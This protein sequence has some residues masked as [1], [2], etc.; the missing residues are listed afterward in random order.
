MPSRA[1]SLLLL[2]IVALAVGLP[3]MIRPLL[4]RFAGSRLEAL[5]AR[6]GL[7]ASWGALRVELPAR[8]TLRDLRV[9]AAGGDTVLHADS[10]GLALDPWALLFGRARVTRIA[11]AHASLRV[12]PTR[13]ADIDTLSPDQPSPPGGPGPERVRRS[14][15]ALVRLLSAPARHL[16]QLALYDVAL[17]SARGADALWNGARLSWLSLSPARGGVRL[18]ATGSI[19]GQR[20]VPFEASFVHAGDDRL[21]GGA[22]LKIPDE[23]GGRSTVRVVADAVV[24][25]ER[26]AD[27]IAIADGSRIQIGT[28]ELRVGGTIRRR[29]PAVEFRLSADRLTDER[30]KGS[31]PSPV[32][33]P[34]R[35]LATRGSWDYR[36][37]FQLDLSRPDSVE[38]SARVV[39][40]GLRLDPERTRLDLLGLDGPFVAS[41]HLPRGHL[42]TR[43][44]SPANPHFRPLEEIVPALVYAVVTNEDGAFFHH[45]GF[46]T[47]AVKGAIV[48]NL[49]AGAFRR[50]AGTITMQLARNLYLGHERTLSRKFQEVTLAWVLEHLTGI[51]KQ[52]LLE[53]YLNIIE[54][55]PGIHGA[56]EAADFYFARDATNLTVDEALFLATVVP[57]PGKWRYRFDP[58]G[59]LR[60]FARAQM[61]FIG[62]AMVAK[63]WLAPEALPAAESLRVELAGAARGVLFPA[64]STTVRSSRLPGSRRERAGSAAAPPEA[65]QPTTCRLPVPAWSRPGARREIHHPIW[66]AS[67]AERADTRLGRNALGAY[68][69]AFPAKTLEELARRRPRSPGRAAQHRV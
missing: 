60:P 17:Q 25:Q 63:G 61:H 14:A 21:T 36:L 31:L 51:S 65:A 54:W 5:A 41:I 45:R 10:L 56:D 44:L 13:T 11:A 20:E 28:I 9:V 52:R 62:R 50:G 39:P 6:R 4:A 33:G 49:R 34:L 3:F 48:E 37:T 69:G 30:I 32:L 29:G 68:H 46:N 53:I 35:D 24:H 27:R 59:E 64:D 2:A 12:P 55:G 23:R 43:E 58:S 57:S 16:P 22:R 15:E 1:R 42:V 40:H 8:T 26:P 19:L 67:R 38:F 18:A 7:T 47:E 66:D